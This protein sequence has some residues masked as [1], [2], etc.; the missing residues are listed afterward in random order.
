M[1]PDRLCDAMAFAGQ[2]DSVKATL[3]SRPRK[4]AFCST[5]AQLRRDN[6]VRARRTVAPG[7]LQR[8]A[9]EPGS[10]RLRM[11]ASGSESIPQVGVAVTREAGKND[12]MRELLVSKHRDNR[13]L[14][15]AQPFHIQVHEIPCITHTQVPEGLQKLDDALRQDGGLGHEFE[16]VVITSP[17][18]AHNFLFAVEAAAQSTESSNSDAYAALANVKVAAVGKATCDALEEGGVSVDFVPS[19]AY[20][21]ALG[22]E[23]PKSD[24]SLSSQTGC[25]VL[26]PASA[27]AQRTLQTTLEQRGFQVTRLNI[28]D[29]VAAV[30]SERE[31]HLAGHSVDI[32]CFASPSAVS[33]WHKEMQ[34]VLPACAVCIGKSSALRCV[35]L[36]MAEHTVFFPQ[37][38][39][40]GSWAEM[41]FVA[42]ASLLEM[43]SFTTFSGKPSEALEAGPQN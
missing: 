13:T 12:T 30:F 38:P 2:L 11:G 35:E 9:Q 26:Y 42:A 27:R 23:L 33:A 5:L 39:G 4:G 1:G 20:A 32:A 37:N 7:W 24:L 43:N 40:V 10:S 8:S 31:R 28:Y 36:G 34:G 29:T 18:A 21:D 22:T 15:S 3:R 6:A 17:E 19:V 41:V 16:W 25:K 14:D